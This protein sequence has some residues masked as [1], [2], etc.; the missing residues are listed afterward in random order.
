MAGVSDR[1]LR[2]FRNEDSFALGQLDGCTAA[3]LCDG[4]SN[5]P[6]ADEASAAAALFIRDALLAGVQAGTPDLSGVM[7]TA[8][9]RAHACVNALAGRHVKADEAA[10]DVPAT[11][12]LAVLVRTAPAY[13]ASAR[14]VTIGWLGDSR[15]YFVAWQGGARLLTKDHSWINEVVDA[16][17]MTRTEALR[18]KNAHTVTRTLGGSPGDDGRPDAPSTVRVTLAEPGWLIL[19]SDG[20]WNYAPE[21]PELAAWVQRLSPSGNDALSLCRALTSEALRQGGRDNVTVIALAV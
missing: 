8:I 9:T 2:H 4:V 18:S 20:L 13:P 21:A 7:D 15:A 5:S 1:G 3:V 17:Q 14:D 11:T 12:V 19:C 10:V 6:R 16:G